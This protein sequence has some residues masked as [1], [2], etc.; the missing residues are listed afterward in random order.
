[1]N[2]CNG[3]A[4]E[5]WKHTFIHFHITRRSLF[6]VLQISSSPSSPSWL[7]LCLRVH[8]GSSCLTILKEQPCIFK[9]FFFCWGALWVMVCTCWPHSAEWRGLSQE[10]EEIPWHRAIISP[11]H[12]QPL[13]YELLF[14]YRCYTQSS[15]RLTVS[16]KNCDKKEGRLFWDTVF[17]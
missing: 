10:G 2:N 14:L 7:Q 16:T 4:A 11:R 13:S 12:Y 6:S 3:F 5:A 9:C 15:A 1:M 17:F 8:S